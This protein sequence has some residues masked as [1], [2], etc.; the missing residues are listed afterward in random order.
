[1]ETP[2]H[3][4][5]HRINIGWSDAVLTEVGVGSWIRLY[6]NRDGAC[7]EVMIESVIELSQAATQVV[8][9]PSSPPTCAP[10]LQLI[11][12][13]VRSVTLASDG[14]LN[15]ELSHCTIRI[16]ATDSYEAWSIAAPEFRVVCGPGG[17]L[18]TWGVF[19]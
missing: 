13:S 9:D 2:A 15:V 3:I 1:M 17:E 19:G 4:V 11:G 8:C 14:S 12:Q 10:L 18:T 6:L 16:P 7:H 5:E